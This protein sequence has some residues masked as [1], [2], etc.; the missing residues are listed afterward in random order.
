M[1]CTSSYTPEVPEEIRLLCMLHNIGATKPEKSL[2]IPEICD[3][4]SKESLDVQSRLQNL[5][6]LDYIGIIDDKGVNKYYVT[7]SGIR[8]VLSTYS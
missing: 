3:W 4:T 6:G 8:K 5:I 2:S 7:I 1:M